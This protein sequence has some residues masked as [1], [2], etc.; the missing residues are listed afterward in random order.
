MRVI[1]MPT[2]NSRVAQV[3]RKRCGNELNADRFA[4]LGDMTPQPI[5]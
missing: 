2:F 1:S 4:D 3:W 5:G